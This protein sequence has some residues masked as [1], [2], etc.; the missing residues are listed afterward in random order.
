[1]LESVGQ[2]KIPK[3]KPTKRMELN[4]RKFDT[5]KHCADSYLDQSFVSEFETCVDCI[6]K[7]VLRPNE[8][9]KIQLAKNI[10]RKKVTATIVKQSRI[11]AK[12]LLHKSHEVFF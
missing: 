5:I 6:Q 3:Y 9:S 2:S 11:A 4:P 7:K 10:M 1:M 8:A 12:T